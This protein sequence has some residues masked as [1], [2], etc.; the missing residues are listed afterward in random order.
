MTREE[1]ALRVAA[2]AFVGDAERGRL[3]RFLPAARRAVLGGTYDRLAATD[4]LERVAR[5]AF[6]PRVNGALLARALGVDVTGRSIAPAV[7]RWA[8]LWG[9]DDE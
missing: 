3:L 6:A 4:E 2:F 7:A 5:A 8:V 9:G 1:H